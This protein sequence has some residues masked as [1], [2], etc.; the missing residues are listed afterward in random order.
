MPEL[1]EVE[2]ITRFFCGKI[3]NKSVL[4]VIIHRA[5]LRIPVG[6]NFRDLV[7]NQK[8]LNIYRKAKYI[9]IL[10]SNHQ[11][12]IIHLGMSGKLFYTKD[13]KFNTHDH[14]VFVLNDKSYVTFNDA[15]RFGLVAIF[16]DMQ[17]VN[18][19]KK[20]GIEPLCKEFNAHYLSHYLTRCSIK[21]LLMN[22]KIVV[23]IGNI[24]ASEILFKARILPYRV[25][26]TL[27]FNECIQITQTTK[28]VLD[29]AIKAGGSTIKDYISPIGLRGYFQE[30]FMVYGRMEQPCYL[31]KSS[32][33]KIKQSGRSTFFCYKCQF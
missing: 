2:V 7:L 9:I 4:D 18:F 32:I 11:R 13:Y 5:D 31:C 15:R 6:K 20:F 24:Y 17:Y 22:N 25:A 14:I 33:Q 23:G 26:D 10:L 12:I 27:S 29:C 8:I 3:L 16:D 1:P 28:V 30:N 21:S 19:C